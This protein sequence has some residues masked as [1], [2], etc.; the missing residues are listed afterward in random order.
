MFEFF[1]SVAVALEFEY[2]GVVICVV[3]YNHAPTFV[4]SSGDVGAV[5]LIEAAPSA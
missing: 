2:L 5:A 4:S 3:E 1:V